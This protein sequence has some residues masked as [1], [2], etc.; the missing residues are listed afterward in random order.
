MCLYLDPKH[1]EKAQ[2]GLGLSKSRAFK[3]ILQGNQLGAPLSDNL[4]SNVSFLIDCIGP[5]EK[6]IASSSGLLDEV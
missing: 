1:P 2:Y 5:I 3:K 4:T 6:S